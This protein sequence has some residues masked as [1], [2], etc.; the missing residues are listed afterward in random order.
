M[1]HLKKKILSLLQRE[2]MHEGAKAACGS[3]DERTAAFLATLSDSA[4]FTSNNIYLC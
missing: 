2:Q 1:Y 3:K 4:H